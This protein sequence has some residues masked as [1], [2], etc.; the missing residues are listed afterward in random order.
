MFD[1]FFV[2]PEILIGWMV[3][4]MSLFFDY[5]PLVAK[6]FE[7]L[8]VASKRLIVLGGSIL[9]GLAAFV[10]PCYGWFE[11]NISC[12][13]SSGLRLLYNVILAVAVSYGFHMQTK[14]TESLQKRMFK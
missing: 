6:K 14:P 2:T 8:T 11:T 12:S 13:Y 7:G 5:F 3:A 9:I 10:G 4:L 1:K